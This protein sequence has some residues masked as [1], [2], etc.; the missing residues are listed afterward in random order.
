M[1]LVFSKLIP[2]FLF[3]LG[4]A[5]LVLLVCLVRMWWPGHH[6]WL[7]GG[8]LLFSVLLL[9]GSGSPYLADRLL[10]RL[11]G[12]YVSQQAD[13]Y[14]RAQAI[15][16]LGGGVT[17]TGR[18]DRRDFPGPS[19]DRLYMGYRLY[20]AGRAPVFVVSGGG[21]AWRK[22]DGAVSESV[23]MAP[24][25][26]QLGVPDIAIIRESSSRNTRENAVY[27]KK[28]LQKRNIQGPVLLVTSASHMT[29]SQACFEKVGLTV[30]PC[31]ADFRVDPYKRTTLLDFLPHAQALEKTTTALHEYV[32]M[33]YYRFRGWI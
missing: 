3:P 24:L 28:L 27:T 19:F 22:K 5:L 2:V 33:V 30:I 23:S 15:V 20:Q 11:E 17:G 6:R 25:L 29:R 16:V 8:L 7:T 10:F 9:W 32:G 31:P 26:R 14:P 13:I 12:D 1:A 4:L 21:I 18:G